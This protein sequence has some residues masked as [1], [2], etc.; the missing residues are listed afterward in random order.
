MQTDDTHAPAPLSPGSGHLP[1]LTGLV[2]VG[3]R[4]SSVQLPYLRVLVVAA[5]VAPGGTDALPPVLHVSV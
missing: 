1:G 3:C 4:G 5:V 2:V